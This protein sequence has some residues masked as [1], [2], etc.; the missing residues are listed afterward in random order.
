MCQ[1][2]EVQSGVKTFCI[3]YDHGICFAIG[4]DEGRCVSLENA[5]E[6]LEMLRKVLE[7]LG[8][9]HSKKVPVVLVG[10]NRCETLDSLEVVR[11]LSTRRLSG[12]GSF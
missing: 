3:A 10:L 11:A 6:V 12:R 8:F 5:Q 1:V 4:V 9:V 2:S 7:V